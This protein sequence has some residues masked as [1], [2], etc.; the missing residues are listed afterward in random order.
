MPM[1]HAGQRI[2]AHL[3]DLVIVAG[4]F[5]GLSL[6]AVQLIPNPEISESLVLIGSFAY[7]FAYFIALETFWNGLTLGKKAMGIRVRMLDGTPVTFAAVV[8]RNVLRPA[9]FLPVM[10]FLGIATMLLN[11]RSQRI[12]D[13]AAGTVVTMES[14]PIRRV[15]AAPHAVGIHAWEDAVGNLRGMTREEYEALRRL[16]D[17]FPELAPEAQDRLIATVLEPIRRR[18]RV[19]DLIQ[20]HPLLIA[21]AMVMKYGRQRGILG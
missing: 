8:A 21:E 19:P 17:R 13:M 5:I 18:R 1:A 3:I 20:V 14:R 4:T 15:V 12:G 7:I 10:Y 2:S 9:D 16:A 11:P 6:L